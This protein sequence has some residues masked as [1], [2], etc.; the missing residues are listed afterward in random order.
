MA[1]ENLQQDIQKLLSTSSPIK[2]RAL[3]TILSREFGLHVDRSN[4]NSALYS[5][6]HDGLVERNDNYEWSLSRQGKQ[7]N[8][9]ADPPAEPEIIFTAEQQA[10]INLA[11]SNH[12]LIRG[13]AGSGKTTVL[14]ARSGRILSALNQGSLLFLTYNSA[15]SAYVKT[16]FLK[17]GMKGSI[18]VRTFHDWAKVTSESLGYEFKGWVDEKQRKEKIYEII[19]IVQAKFSPHRLYEIKGNSEL[20][21]W[22]SEEIA[23][24]FGQYVT[25]LDEYLGIERKGRG[26]SIRL[27]QEDRKSVWFVYEAYQE[28]L[29]ES[30]QED[31]DNPAGLILR[32]LME[33]NTSLPDN[34]RYDHVLV[35]EVQDFDKSWLLAVVKIPRVSLTLAGDLAQKIYKRNFTWTSVGINVRGSRSRYLSGSHR[36][37]KQIMDVASC[38]LVGNSI[39]VSDDYVSPISPSRSGD[40]VR[41]I[42]S[43]GARDAYEKGYDYIADSFKRLRTANVAVALPFTKQL[44]PAKEAL[45]IRKLDADIAKGAKLGRLPSGIFITTYHQLK[46]LEFDHVVILGLH[47]AQYPGRLLSSIAQEDQVEEEQLMKRVLYVAMT[48]AKKTVTLVGSKPFCRFFN[49]MPEDLFTFVLDSP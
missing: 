32:C 46:G 2:A 47:D 43:S 12:L 40:K 41:I 17:S 27:S 45:R 48:R 36:T 16:A 4:I 6:M 14:A 33:K 1:G 38:L 21:R 25:K 8:V 49:E 11:P 23:W 29:E 31:Y 30:C 9:I 13:Q 15:L 26:S 7:D 42:I 37:T 19:E 24:L 10:V 28:W 5:M 39:T 18:D 44:Y 20:L 3:A 22:W 34:L 35:D